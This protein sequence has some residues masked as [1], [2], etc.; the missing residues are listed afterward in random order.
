MLFIAI[1]EAGAKGAKGAKGKT[2]ILDGIFLDT[3]QELMENFEVT[4]KIERSTE[5]PPWDK[6]FEVDTFRELTDLEK[7][8]WGRR[9]DCVSG[10]SAIGKD[11]TIEEMTRVSQHAPDPLKRLV[12]LPL[13]TSRKPRKDE[14]RCKNVDAIKDGA[15]HIFVS[16]DKFQQM[17]Q[18]Q[19]FICWRRRETGAYY[20]LSYEVAKQIF[21]NHPG[22]VLVSCG[23]RMSWIIDRCFDGYPT[24]FYIR[25]PEEVINRWYRECKR[26]SGQR[27][28]RLNF[29]VHKWAENVADFCINIDTREELFRNLFGLKW[30]QS[31]IGVSRGGKNR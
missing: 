12:R 7:L 17:I 10:L 26:P 30:I 27:D 15:Y 29:E 6:Y 18:N 3:Y 19:E 21:L 20:G 11:W 22:Y 16:S 1:T 28:K 13:V 5:K 4:R 9:L 2:D 23:L 25:A 14:H 24:V 8:T 31:E